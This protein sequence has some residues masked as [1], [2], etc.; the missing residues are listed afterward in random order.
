VKKVPLMEIQRALTSEIMRPMQIIHFGIMAGASS[1]FLIII[2]IYLT[3]QQGFKINQQDIE[4]IN[5][6]SIVHSVIF[7][8]CLILSG[9]IYKNML[10]EKK[11]ESMLNKINNDNPNP[12]E[13][14]IGIIRTSQIIYTAILEAPAFFGLVICFMAITNN[15]IYEYNY[16]WLNAVSYFAFIYLLT[17]GFPTKEKL[18]IIFQTQ[19]KYLVSY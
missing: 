5:T 10:S 8:S 1:F 9:V 13:S 11:V 15:V 17:K 2:F 4:T 3:N 14:Y 7:I 18:L 6:L 16:Y 12:V 19:L